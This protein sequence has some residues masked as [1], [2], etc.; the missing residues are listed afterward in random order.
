MPDRPPDPSRP[1]WRRTQRLQPHGHGRLLPCR[2]VLVVPRMAG[3]CPGTYPAS[4]HKAMGPLSHQHQLARI[5][6]ATRHNAGL[7]SSQRQNN[8]HTP[9]STP[10]L[11]PQ[12]RQ[13]CRTGVAFQ[14][15]H[16]QRHRLRTRSATSLPPPRPRRGLS[17]RPSRHKNQHHCRRHLTYPV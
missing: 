8:D 17:L 14:R 15:M 7:T 5:R 13:H 9:R 12:M 11:P 6:S 4:H 3:R 10:S 1:L 2:Q 16:L